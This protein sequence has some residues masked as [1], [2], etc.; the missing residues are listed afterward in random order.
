MQEL[1]K[2]TIRSMNREELVDNVVDLFRYRDVL[3]REQL[4][5]FMEERAKEL[6]MQ[7]AFQRLLKAAN[8]AD[9]KLADEYT[10]ANA[11]MH[12]GIQLTFDAKGK[13][14]ETIDNY[15]QIFRVDDKFR[16]LRYNQF[17]Q[18]PEITEN[19]ETR[20]WAPADDSEALHYIERKYEIYHP[21]RYRHAMRVFYRERGYHPVREYIDSLKWDGVP[22][23]EHFLTKWMGCENTDYIQEVSRLMFAGG[24]H[25]IYEPGIKFDTV[26]VLIGTKQGEGKTML[27]HWLAIKDDWY[28][29]LTVFDGKEGI[30]AIQGTWICEIG[31][32]LAVARAKE[33]EAIKSY[34][35]RQADKY[36]VPYAERPETFHRQCIFIGTTNNEQ[37]LSDKTGN[38]RWLPVH[39]K[40]NGYEL[41]KQEKEC[42]AYIEQC[43]AE[44][45]AK[46]NDEFTELAPRYELLDVIRQKQQDAEEEDWREDMI[47]TYLSKKKPGDCI[48][49][50]QL[51]QEAL[52]MS[53]YDKPSP[54]EQKA[55]RLIMQ[56]FPEWERTSAPVYF[57]KYGSTRGWK[58]KDDADDLP[59]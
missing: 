3:K 20:I 47:E 45:R 57:A 7:R 4:A 25:R 55:I 59:F 38:R 28:S 43:W 52:N 44:A 33:V 34:I 14:A 22:R 9:K 2:E 12:S 13:P 26:P 24:I 39:V 1:T 23:V 21:E 5:V 56:K 48:C 11:S 17:K 29:E 16:T 36:R 50:M 40:M 53:E 58:K 54:A 30:E 15:L 27:L 32:L 42:R 37:F 19:L 6:G 51:Y 49:T 10:A 31:E 35:T 8:D 46:Y 18:V 41:F